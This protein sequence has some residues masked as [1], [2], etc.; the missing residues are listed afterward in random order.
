MYTVTWFQCNNNNN[1]ILAQ[2]DFKYCY[3]TQ[4]IQFAISQMVKQS[5]GIQWVLHNPQSSRSEASQSDGDIRWGVSYSPVE[6]HSKLGL[7][8]TSTASLQR[9]NPPT[10]VLVMT[11]NN[12]TV[13]FRQCWSFGECGVPFH[14]HRSQVTSGP[15]W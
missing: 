8:N 12:L 6:L 7:S 1:S 15:D 3:I 4:I 5:N 13:R 11:L 2:N 14:C 10:S 9:D